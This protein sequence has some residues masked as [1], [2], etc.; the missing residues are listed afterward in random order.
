MRK[1]PRSHVNLLLVRNERYS[2]EM[3]KKCES[4]RIS[5]DFYPVTVENV[6]N[7]WRDQW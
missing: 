3:V 6:D 7:D 4:K 2:K 5:A 1:V